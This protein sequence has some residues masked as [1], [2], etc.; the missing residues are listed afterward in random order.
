MRRDA[1]IFLFVL[2][3]LFFSWPILGIFGDSLV[4]SLF[5]VWLVFIAC[6]FVASLFPEREDGGG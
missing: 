3:V 5:I 2:G 4:L 6:I 1:W